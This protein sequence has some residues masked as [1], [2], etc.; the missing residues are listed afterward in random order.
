MLLRAAK[1]ARR[2]HFEKQSAIGGKGLIGGGAASGSGAASGLRGVGRRGHGHGDGRIGDRRG[3]WRLVAVG[4]GGRVHLKPVA[5]LAAHA[6][7]LDLPQHSSAY[8][9]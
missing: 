5:A 2:F 3:D 6:E 9:S 4:G 7:R 1:H 8:G